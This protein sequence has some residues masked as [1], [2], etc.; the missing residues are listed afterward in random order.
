VPPARHIGGTVVAR[1]LT[2]VNVER[3]T[4]HV[5]WMESP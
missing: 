1:C 2:P 5:L 4:L 3:H